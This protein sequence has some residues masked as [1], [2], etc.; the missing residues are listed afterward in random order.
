[1][2]LT[3]Q[4]IF[5]SR[6]EISVTTSTC[7]FS[8]YFVATT[9]SLVETLSVHLA[10]IPHR[11]IK[12]LLRPE[13]SSFDVAIYRMV[14]RHDLSL[15]LFLCLSNFSLVAA[16]F[17]L[18]QQLSFGLEFFLFATSILCRDLRSLSNIFAATFSLKSYLKTC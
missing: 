9:N 18:S 4:P 11:D 8:L 17:L 12:Y 14:S 10:T 2:L 15:K 1:M 5:M 16:T 3:V 6:H 13:L 7:V